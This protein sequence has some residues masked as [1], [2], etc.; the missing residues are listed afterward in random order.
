M[1]QDRTRMLL[2]DRRLR[3]VSMDP[4]L[5][6]HILN[7][8]KEP[9]CVLALP[10]TEQI[11]SDCIAVSVNA[12]WDRGTIDVIVAHESFERSLPG[13]FLP[14]VDGIVNSLRLVS[15]QDAIAAIPAS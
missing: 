13:S 9:D 10:A 3:I 14:R 2:E 15:L 5:L 6:V 7:W 11:P 1:D 8:A 4:K 12:C